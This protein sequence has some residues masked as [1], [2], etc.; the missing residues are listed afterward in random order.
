MKNLN[1]TNSNLVF[2]SNLAIASKKIIIYDME[3]F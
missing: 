1:E 2:T 3:D